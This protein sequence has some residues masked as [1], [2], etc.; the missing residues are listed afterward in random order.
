MGSGLRQGWGGMRGLWG[1]DERR[2]SDGVEKQRK[3]SWEISM[4]GKSPLVPDGRHIY[5]P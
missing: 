3:Y 1:G 5:L 2:Y 4:K